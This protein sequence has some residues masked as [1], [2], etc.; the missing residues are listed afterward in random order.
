MLFA[1]PAAQPDIIRDPFWQFI[2]VI[3]AL[4]AIIATIVIF[5]FQRQKKSLAYEIQ[6]NTPVLTISEQVAGKVKVL[7]EDK[8]IKNAQLIVIKLIN[9]GNQPITS[10]DYERN[11]SCTFGVNS[12]ILSSEIIE[13][14][15]EE[16]KPKLSVNENQIVL[17]ALLLNEKDFLVIKTLVADFK[18]EIDIDA[19]IIGVKKISQISKFDSEKYISAFMFGLIF[20]FLTLS[21]LLV[22]KNSIFAPQVSPFYTILLATTTTGVVLSAILV[23]F[24]FSFKKYDD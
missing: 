3:L 22:F 1:E 21:F 13:P 8:P 23:V 15:P 16:L 24:R 10:N 7:Y 4:I 11:F 12:K 17:E 9:N 5:Y 19:R 14:T 18:D 20:L 2:G 6:T